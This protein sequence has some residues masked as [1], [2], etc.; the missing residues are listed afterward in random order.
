MFTVSIESAILTA[1]PFLAFY[2]VSDAGFLTPWRLVRITVAVGLLLALLV[3]RE[4]V[5]KYLDWL[6]LSSAVEGGFEYNQL[7]PP[8]LPRSG[9]PMHPNDTAL[10][11]D[12]I[13]PM[14]ALL[15]VRPQARLDRNLGLCGGL[16]MLAATVATGC[17]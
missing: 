15:V 11:L 7:V 13:V 9:G 8:A 16:L 17:P 1:S 3:L 14:S 4:E 2:A 10:V 6:R 5:A 12:L